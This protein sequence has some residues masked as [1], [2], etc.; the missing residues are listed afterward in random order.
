MK[1]REAKPFVPPL[2]CRQQVVFSNLSNEELLNRLADS[3]CAS[4][5][6]PSEQSLEEYL[7]KVQT[8]AELD[9]SE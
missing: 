6:I 8:V 3:P 4:R 1:S 2:G 9:S 7:L 5:S